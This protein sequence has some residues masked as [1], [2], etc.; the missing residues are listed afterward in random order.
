MSQL[1]LSL[2]G[3][4]V[5]L[6]AAQPVSFRTKKS[7]ALLIYLAVEGGIHTRDQ[8]A[9]L[10]WPEH[11]DS[12]AR[13]SLR[14]VLAQ[15]R[16][17]LSYADPADHLI[18]QSDQLSID[19]QNV[20]LDLHILA[21]AYQHTLNTGSAA[22]DPAARLEQFQAALD[23][24]RGDFLA[25]FAL[26][27][28]P[29]FDDWI[30]ARR[31]AYRWQM[32]HVLDHFS[33]QLIDEGAIGQAFNVAQR[34]LEH[35]PLSEAANRRMIELYLARGDRT[36]ALQVYESYRGRL[37]DELG[38][39]PASETIAL[40]ERTQSLDRPAP[41]HSQSTALSIAAPPV[42]TPPLMGRTSE[43]AT[44]I[45]AY[46][47]MAQGVLQ[48]VTIVGESGIGK[49][50]LADEFLG[51]VTAQGGD[52]LYGRAIELSTM[53]P[54]QPVIDALRRRLEQERAPD[55]LLSDVWL[56][57][58]SRLLPEIHDRYPDLALP[59][60]D[61]PSARTR[62]F[63]A[64]ARLLHALAEHRPVVFFLDDLHWSDAASLDLLS[65]VCQRS[66]EHV[67]LLFLLA[68]RSDATQPLSERPASLPTWLTA[69]Q[70][71]T[72]I[73]QISLAS[74]SAETVAQ[75]IATLA[76][77]EHDHGPDEDQDQPTPLG[78]APRSLQLFSDWL[79]AETSG[80]PFY[81]VETIKTLMEQGLLAWRLRPDG[82]WI[83]ELGSAVQHMDRLQNFLPLGV[84]E[85][86]HARIQQLSPHAQDLAIAGAVLGY[87][88]SFEQLCRV[89][90]LSERDGLA[91]LDELIHQHILH[92]ATG[93]P[94]TSQPD[95]YIF[96][97]DKIRDVVYAGASPTRRRVFH[98]RALA[99]LDRA[100]PA[101]LAHH[102]LAAGLAED[103]L[104]YSLEAGDCALNMFAISDA[105]SHYER[106]RQILAEGL[107]PPIR[108]VQIR[109]LFGQ[110]GRAYELSNQI[111]QAD[112]T[113][114]ELLSFARETQRPALE[115]AALNRLAMLVSQNERDLE[116]A[117]ALLEVARDVAHESGDLL[118]LAETEWSLAQI[119]FY[120]HDLTAAIAHGEQALAL[121]R[122]LAL[123]DL[124]AR[125][126]NVLA[127][128]KS[129]IGCWDSTISHAQEA[130]L[131]HA[132]QGNRALEADSLSL[133]STALISSGRLPEGLSAARAASV[134]SRQIDNPWGQAHSAFGLTMALI[135]SGAYA[136]A[137]ALAQHGVATAR[138]LN[139]PQLLFLN[140][141]GLGWIQREL[142]VFDQA[143]V[144]HTE[145]L[146][147]SQQMGHRLYADFANAAL[148]ADFAL[149]GS[150][151]QASYYARQ[152]L[153]QRD[154]RLRVFL[155]ACRWLEIQALLRSGEIDRANE[156]LRLFEQRFGANPRHRIDYLRA[157]AVLALHHGAIEQ[158]RTELHEAAELAATLGLPGAR[159]QILAALSELYQNMNDEDRALQ[160]AGQS[161]AIV[162]QLAAQLVDPE[163][164]ATFLGGPAI[165]RIFEM[166]QMLM[167][168]S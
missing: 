55:D 155:G 4:P 149:D 75:M 47:T 62:L 80:Q 40:A 116:R 57:E 144:L 111:A 56:T 79:F 65:Y 60:S 1:N 121:A 52:V 35:E 143:R 21:A 92:E 41:T 134:I 88:A 34:W 108:T 54:Y 37:V 26:D 115:S 93:C 166:P 124:L 157:S 101:E 141:M 11:T 73:T 151:D 164:A 117:L 53:L 130:R 95:C 90:D 39:E 146:A 15:L 67:P 96:A 9:M 122:Q 110:L 104:Q 18:T 38:I 156:D 83:L 98:R 97:H 71:T 103:A 112:A 139:F 77:A 2:L 31:A 70:R 135:E 7:L 102:A 44:L 69:L 125:S 127:Y 160:M 106:A 94:F 87:R 23:A 12:Q 46:R 50:Q 36:A 68:L 74:L 59:T 8:L 123:P 66:A 78:Y 25:G 113:Y 150:W 100:M 29:D 163:L 63:E 81:I 49:T 82:S 118:E 10:L 140:L 153:D 167:L 85:L 64:I 45:A 147:L 132:D 154:Y 17:S 27:E 142:H 61:E 161:A 14:G 120:R 99:V 168:S 152:A 84:R 126:L 13:A 165:Q 58:L 89:A 6:H 162:H 5:A 119:N 42:I 30:S 33:R 51:W 114:Q 3:S 76:R 148:C 136:E 145:A 105:I 24:Y 131:L 86:I 129:T 32:S 48:V 72:P 91:A 128:A 28:A 19:Q 109:Q 43:Y 107:S 16:R 133:L 20:T 138:T 22:T 159:W 137:L 158:A